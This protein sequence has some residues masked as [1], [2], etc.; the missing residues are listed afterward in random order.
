MR[1]AVLTDI[2][3]YLVAL[4]TVIEDIDAWQPD[5]VIAAGDVPVSLNKSYSSLISWRNWRV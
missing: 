3:A 4:N 2:H 1:I 5:Y